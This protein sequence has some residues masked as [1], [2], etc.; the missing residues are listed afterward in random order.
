[1]K[2]TILEFIQKE[3]LALMESIPELVRLE[4]GTKP[5]G[6]VLVCMSPIEPPALSFDGKNLPVR[7]VVESD[8]AK[9][10]EPKDPNYEAWLKRHPK[11]DNNVIHTPEKITE[12]PTMDFINSRLKK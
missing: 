12:V 8:V 10:V 3:S 5:V 4:L 1:M 11:I 9:V 7:V 2:K 6:L